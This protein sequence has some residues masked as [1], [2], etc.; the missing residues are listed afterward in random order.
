MGL[1][2]G[3]ETNGF[4][5][6]ILEEIAKRMVMK[7]EELVS[8]LGDKVENPSSYVQSV[9]KALSDQ[10]L[11]TYVSPLGQGCYAITQKGMREV[12]K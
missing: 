1:V 5:R 11:I 7:K 2:I 6:Q 8:F 12:G 9:T 4:Q 3:L 10:G